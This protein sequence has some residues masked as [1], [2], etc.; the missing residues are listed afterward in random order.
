MILDAAKTM[1]L[2]A[3]IQEGVSTHGMQTFDQSLMD[4]YTRNLITLE[5]AVRN[6]SNPSEFQLRIEGIHA[7]SDTSWRS[8]EHAEPQGAARRREEAKAA[9]P[10]KSGWRKV[11]NDGG[12]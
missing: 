4:L 3:A 6:A 9:A 10:A 7:T 5:E 2:P 11:R 12:E 1:N 8:F